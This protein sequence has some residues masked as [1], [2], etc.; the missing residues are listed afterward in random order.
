MASAGVKVYRTDESGTIVTTTDGT[1][2]TF[3]ARPSE[4]KQVPPVQEQSVTS[5]DVV[6]SEL[7][8]ENEKVTIRNNG[9]KDVD[10]TGWTLVSEEENQTF[11]FPDGFV[12]KAGSSVNIW[13]GPN[14]KHNP[15]TDLKWT[16]AY[17]WNN[18]GDTAA[19]YDKS[20]K[21]VDRVVK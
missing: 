16:G 6:I 20:G 8:L 17:I 19:L 14:A 10:L 13:S 3:N 11:K 5:V 12:L 4:I 15:P 18:D 7:D 2:I 9:S 1:T 21:L